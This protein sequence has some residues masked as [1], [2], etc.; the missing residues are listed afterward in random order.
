MK[1]PLRFTDTYV[2]LQ[3]ALGA[4]RGEKDHAPYGAR[5]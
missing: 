3:I 4:G 5:A 2:R 1:P